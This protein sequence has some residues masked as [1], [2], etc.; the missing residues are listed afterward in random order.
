MFYL[1]LA[2]LVFVIHLGFILFI[3]FAGLGMVRWPWMIWLHLPAMCWGLMIILYRWIC[4]LTP[5]ENWLLVQGGAAPYTGGF[6]AE[7]LRP[8]IYT[9]GPDIPLSLAVA[10]VLITVLVNGW[11]YYKRIRKYLSR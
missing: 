5:L 10:L 6:L 2:D 3:I 1:I 7:Y 4:P 8:V 11:P 9:E